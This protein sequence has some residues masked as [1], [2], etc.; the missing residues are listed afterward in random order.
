[1]ISYLRIG[2]YFLVYFVVLIAEALIW[3]FP[4]LGSFCLGCY[5]MRS[6]IFGNSH[7]QSDAFNLL[8]SD[9]SKCLRGPKSFT[10]ASTFNIGV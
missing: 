4:K 1:M 8:S 6:P 3:E 9:R 2:A 10:G 5:I 7:I